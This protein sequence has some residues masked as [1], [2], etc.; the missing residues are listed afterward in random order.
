MVRYSNSE[1]NPARSAKARGEYLRVHFKN[2]RE[3]AAAISGLP[4]AKALKYLGDV[5]EHK[6]C[7]P[8]RRFNGGVGRCAQAKQFGT[9]QGRWPAKSAN[10]MLDLLKNAEANAEVKGLNMESLV[11]RYVQVNQAP[12]QRR[13]TYR[14]HGR[15][16]PY[17]ASPCHIELIVTE[18]D[19]AV[20]RE[21]DG[22][23]KVVRL[24]R[25][26][27]AR[28]AAVVARK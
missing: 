6:Q 13:R 3:V 25:R 20:K 14:A 5:K 11:L 28:K 15:I 4:L 9:T 2:T 17:M 8:F 7:I 22:Q 27:A 26:L 21:D 18:E 1:V 10:F 24:N 19:T 16:N 23:G 12:K